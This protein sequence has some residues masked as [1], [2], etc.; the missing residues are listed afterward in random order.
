M[1]YVLEPK[2]VT[3][4]W[5]EDESAPETYDGKYSN[6]PVYRGPAAYRLHTGEIVSL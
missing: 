5:C 1:V 6:A 2:Y 4:V 3:A